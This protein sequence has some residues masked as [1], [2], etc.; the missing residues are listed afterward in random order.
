MLI[1]TF[2]STVKFS[3]KIPYFVFPIVTHAYCQDM[4][5]LSN[6]SRGLP[7]ELNPTFFP[8]LENPESTDVRKGLPN[9]DS[10][11]E[12]IPHRTL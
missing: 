8:K 4:L 3:P 12:G 5:L 7:K 11:W 1:K 2:T 9:L 10:S 6:T